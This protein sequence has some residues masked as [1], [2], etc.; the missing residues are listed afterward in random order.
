MDSETRRSW[1]SGRR[2]KIFFF[3]FFVFF[4]CIVVQGSRHKSPFDRSH[5]ISIII[6]I[7]AFEFRFVEQSAFVTSTLP[8]VG[9]MNLFKNRYTLVGG[10]SKEDTLGLDLRP[11]HSYRGGRKSTRHLRTTRISGG[12]KSPL[13]FPAEKD[14]TPGVL[15]SGL[16]SHFWHYTIDSLH[17]FYFAKRVCHWLEKRVRG[18]RGSRLEGFA[19]KLTDP[20]L[21]RDR[22]IRRGE[23]HSRFT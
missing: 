2:H 13:V 1:S 10:R 3:F 11:R 19:H 17:L 7:L 5:L 4:Y 22:P 14:M 6:T 8:Q 16:S 9:L 15:P 12:G 20:V 23:D 18:R 21:S